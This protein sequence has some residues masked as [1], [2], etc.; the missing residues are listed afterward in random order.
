S[1][2]DA[3]AKSVSDSMFSAAKWA[4]KA[5]AMAVSALA[6]FAVMSS[7]ARATDVDFQSIDR[8]YFH[9]HEGSNLQDNIDGLQKL[10]GVSGGRDGQVLWRLCRAKVR[11]A[12]KIEKR[13]DKLAGYESAKANCEEGVALSSTSAEAHF[14][15]GVTIGRWGETK[16]L[17][18]ALFII[19]PLKKEMAEVL[20]LDPS[21]GGAHNVLGEILW[22]LPGFVGGDKRQALSEFEAAI[23]LSPNYTANHQPLAEAYLHFK[24]KDDAIRVLKMVEAVK[25]PADP[26]EYPDN[27][28]DAK[29]LLEKIDK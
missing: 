8:Q 5:A 3:G 2:S 23:R 17:M 26:A 13:S 12:E 9:R 18:K 22:Q 16:G 25:D 29:L 7:P 4:S 19:K 15:L 21:H 1:F 14:W 11:R 20:R 24:R 28:A 6:A 10:N 27:L